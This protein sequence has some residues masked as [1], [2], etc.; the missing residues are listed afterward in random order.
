MANAFISTG[1]VWVLD[2]VNAN[3]VT[4]V[5]LLIRSIRWVGATTA[6]HQLVFTDTDDATLWESVASG[7]NYVEES[8]V[9]TLWRAGFKL[10]TLGSG[11]AY[12][13]LTS[14]AVR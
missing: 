5:D 12:I 13:T 8:Q 2:T 4:T 7:A 14:H 10:P 11:I 3:K 1:N 6:G 9:N